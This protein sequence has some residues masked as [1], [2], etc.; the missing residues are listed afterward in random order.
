MY[1]S[2]AP[3]LPAFMLRQPDGRFVGGFG[4]A[5]VVDTAR[6][7]DE[8]VQASTQAFATQ[9][10]ARIRA[11]PHFWYQFYRYRTAGEHSSSSAPSPV[12]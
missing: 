10:E 11:T 4:E 9:L 8:G 3:L 12:A 2:G 6:P 7:T 5:I 1:L